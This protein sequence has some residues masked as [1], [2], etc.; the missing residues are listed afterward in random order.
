MIH[1]LCLIRQIYEG[2][3][4]AILALCLVRSFFTFSVSLLSLF[5]TIFSQALKRYLFEFSSC[6]FFICVICKVIWFH[7]SM[8]GY[9]QV[10]CHQGCADRGVGCDASPHYFQFARKLVNG[11]HA[12]RKLTKAF[13]LN[14]SSSYAYSIGQN[15]PPPTESVSAHHCMLPVAYSAQVK[16]RTSPKRP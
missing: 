5:V 2:T 1:P 10:T 7:A 9:C 14:F 15:A 11:Q 3:F 4:G 13:S 6:Y 8:L 16:V 12:A